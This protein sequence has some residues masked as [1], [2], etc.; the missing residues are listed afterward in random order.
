[1]NALFDEQFLRRLESLHLVAR[2]TYTGQ[3]RADRRSKKVGSGL[4]FAD[5]RDYAP[6]DDFRYIDWKVFARMERMLVRLHEE[7]EDLMVYL[8]LD[9]SRSMTAGAGTNTKFDHAARLTA[10]LAYIGLANLDRV[11]LVPFGESI[12]GPLEALRGKRQIFRVF[13][14]LERVTPN[15]K[16]SLST[17]VQTF[18]RRYK[19]RG[20]A[21]VLSDFYDPDGYQDA[22]NTL[23]YSGFETLAI[24]VTDE[25][26]LAADWRGDLAMVDCETG[27]V[28]NV[29]ITPKLL[30]RYR[31]AHQGFCSELRTFCR[32]QGVSYLKAPIHLPFEECI[33]EAFRSGGILK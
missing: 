29:T 25:T 14:R 2:K 5:H 33:L 16:T 30:Q 13:D 24:Q 6:G 18:V 11:C 3:L 8:L 15:G 23:R 22:L 27:K 17:S 7:E 19:R 20:L 31:E 12:L 4:E 21:I 28:R 10:A 32:K 1:M 26:E 9:C